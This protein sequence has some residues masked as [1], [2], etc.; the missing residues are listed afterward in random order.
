MIVR[1]GIVAGIL[2]M[3][4][5]AW[6]Q[7]QKKA[8]PS[9]RLGLE[10]RFDWDATS[11]EWEKEDQD[12]ENSRSEKFVA[13]SPLINVFGTLSENTSYRIRYNLQSDFTGASA[14]SDGLPSGI[15]YLYVTHKINDQLSL[16]VGKQ[17]V[18][19]GSWEF[20]YSIAQLYH[21]SAT[22]L[23]APSLF[24]TGAQLGWN[25]AGQ[26]FALQLLNSVPESSRKQSNEMIKV[27][28][29]Y[30]NFGDGA[31]QPIVSYA[32]FPRPRDKVGSIR[33]DKTETTE[34]SYGTRINQGP[35]EYELVGGSVRSSDYTAY[36]DDGTGVVSEVRTPSDAWQLIY[37]LVR[38]KVADPRIEPFLK[39]TQDEGKTSGEK[40]HSFTRGSI[41]LEYFP[42]SSPLRYHL[43]HVRQRDRYLAF[44]RDGVLQQAAN[45]RRQSSVLLGTGANF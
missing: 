25:V 39:I 35:W 3:S 23:K 19:T 7:E 33:D 9:A 31:I 21:Y 18:L 16:Q 1:F 38:Y 28:A 11:V 15:H 27:L 12:H 22:F 37:G 24:E 34:W 20:N 2:G 13:A 42:E 17:F 8:E 4:P 10:L 6:A 29:W 45:E 32:I 44:S 41:G 36:R 14:G 43:V 30:G 26:F 5:W 40:S